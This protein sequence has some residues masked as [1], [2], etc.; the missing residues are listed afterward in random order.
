MIGGQK[1]LR[2]VCDRFQAYSI[3][4]ATSNL[5]IRAY[6]KRRLPLNDASKSGM[7]GGRLFD[8]ADQIIKAA[9]EL[10]KQLQR[11]GTVEHCLHLLSS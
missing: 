5:S 3:S 7:H 4:G 2:A 11:L 1:R 9:I 6:P 10:G 8:L